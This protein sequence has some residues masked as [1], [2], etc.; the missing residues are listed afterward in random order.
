MHI[1]CATGDRSPLTATGA[2]QD[3]CYFSIH[4]A[5]SSINYSNTADGHLT[6]RR[7]L[8]SAG[9]LSE[10][11]AQIV[12]SHRAP[13]DGIDGFVTLTQPAEPKG[14]SCRSFTVP[15]PGDHAW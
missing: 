1:G 4:L 14:V 2:S 10:S 9:P 15:G 13:A 5:H 6:R 12:P 8:G 3:L 7:S 11:V